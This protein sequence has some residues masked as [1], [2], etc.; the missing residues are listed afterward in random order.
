MAD[1]ALTTTTTILTPAVSTYYE[2]VF[3]KRA[4]Y[5]MILEQGGQKRSHAQNEGKTINFTRLDKLAINSTALGEGC[6]P[7]VS[8]L[9]A[10]TVSVTLA[11]YGVTAPVAKFL[12]LTSID[13]NMAE[14]IGVVGQQMGESLNRLVRNQLMSG[15]A[16]YGNGHAIDTI[17]AGDTL[18][19]CDIRTM[20][21]TLELN[22]ARAYPD[23]YFMGKVS[24]Y[25]KINLLGDSTWVNAKT[26]S[27]VSDL[28]KGEMGSLYQ[29]RFLL[30]GDYSTGTEAAS[31]AAS[32]VT[33]DYSFFHGA[34]GF[35][36]YDLEGDKPKLTILPNAVDSAS[37]AGRRSYISW[38]GSY[39]VKILNADW[40]L[41][42]AN[43][44]T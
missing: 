18:D 16:K 28:Y 6:N 37:P 44:L 39:A 3:L 24:S 12:S 36:V 21:Q 31:L 32:G 17:A 1:Q 25:S 40:V 26:Y 9:A 4:E 34:D 29:V 2:K 19:A 33:R 11:E 41:R 10:S 14:M 5:P 35:G 30:N 42:L 27:D 38:A 15:T 8:C 20:V 22:G 43:T 7:T 13:K 23:G